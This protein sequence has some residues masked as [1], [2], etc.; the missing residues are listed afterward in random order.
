MIA[1]QPGRLVDDHRERRSVAF[2]KG[3]TAKRAQLLTVYTG[4]SHYYRG[5]LLDAF[6]AARFGDQLRLEFI[7][8][9]DHTFTSPNV[10]E[11]LIDIVVDW[12]GSTKFVG[13]HDLSSSKC[14]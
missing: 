6:P 7:K 9:A 10:R 14:Q 4:E 11:R 1:F 8:D 12:A 2:R 3:I 5:K 13:S